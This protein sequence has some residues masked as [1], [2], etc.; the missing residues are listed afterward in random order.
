MT[1]EVPSKEADAFEF[2]LFQ[3]ATAARLSEYEDQPPRS[4][5]DQLRRR[6]CLPLLLARWVP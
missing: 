1:G 6:P 5:Q 3:A 2:L 4:P